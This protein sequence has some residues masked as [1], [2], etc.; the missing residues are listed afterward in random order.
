MPMV[1]PCAVPLNSLLQRYQDGVGYAD[2]YVAEVPFAVTQQAFIE[3]FYTSPLFK[4]ERMLLRVFAA[5]PAT[6]ADVYQ[7]ALG[8]TQSFSAWRVE[9]QSDDELLLADFTGRTRSWLATLAVSGSGHKWAH[10]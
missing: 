6:D 9:S 8:Q 4:V 2:C 7:L 5:R 3:A 10:G 1:R